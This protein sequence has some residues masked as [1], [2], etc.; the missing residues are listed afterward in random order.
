MMAPI[1]NVTNSSCYSLIL[2]DY[3]SGKLTNRKYS[4]IDEAEL[5]CLSF[6]GVPGSVQCL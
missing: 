2:F 6:Q 5:S 3:L 4:D 1:I